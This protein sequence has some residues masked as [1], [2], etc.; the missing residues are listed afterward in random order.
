[1]K[2][3]IVLC[4]LLAACGTTPPAL[5]TTVETPE[6]VQ[7]SN[8]TLPPVVL[9]N[10]DML[11]YDVWNCLI[12]TPK[13]KT[14]VLKDLENFIIIDQPDVLMIIPKHKEQEVKMVHADVKGKFGNGKM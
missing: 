12:R 13:G 10:P 8:A 5:P 11:M 14:V 1:M 3:T 4:S 2:R 7:K 9:D 6:L